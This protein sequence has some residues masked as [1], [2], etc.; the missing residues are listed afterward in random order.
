MKSL[1]HYLA[2]ADKQYSYKIK[3]AASELSDDCMNAIEGILAKYDLVSVSA[4]K[5]TVFQSRPMDFDEDVKGEI[6]IMDAV[7]RLPLSGGVVRELISRKIGLP[8][9]FVQVRGENDPMEDVAEK[10]IQDVAGITVGESDGDDALLN[11]E[12]EESKI[13]FSDYYGTE[14]NEKVVKDEI[15][16]RDSK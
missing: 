3:V 8:L 11:T 2:E 16:K 1:R 15:A 9:K 14:Y 4:P 10:T 12:P 5:K 7:T 13:N 6:Q